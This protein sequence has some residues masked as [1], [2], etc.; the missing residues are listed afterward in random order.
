MKIKSSAWFAAGQEV[1][2]AL[3]LLSDGAFRLYFYL[4]LNANRSA[5]LLAVSYSDLAIAL[6]RSRRSI[7]AYADELR[8]NG[9]CKVHP[10]ANQHQRSEIEICDD[11]W[12]YIKKGTNADRSPLEGD[13]TQIQ[14]FLSERACVRCSFTAA[15]RKVATDLLERNVPLEQIERAVALGCSRKYVSMLNGTDSGFI[16]SFSYFRDLIEEAGDG[17]TP[18][19]YWDYLKHQLKHLETR[20]IAKNAGDAEFTSP[21]GCAQKLETR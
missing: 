10:A 15:D 3:L 20:W 1:E 13:I 16:L 2:R 9:I 17:K 7:A 19:G 4:C 21:A 11:F 8:R 12:P 14:L 5:G 6:G 18:A